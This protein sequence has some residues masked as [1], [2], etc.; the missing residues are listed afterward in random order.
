MILLNSA[1]P[2]PVQDPSPVSKL[3]RFSLT[4]VRDIERVTG[5]DFFPS[6]SAQQQ[7]TLELRIT[8]QLWSTG[9]M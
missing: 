7:N 9:N 1:P 6:L 4:P 3:L 8:N 2:L 5:V